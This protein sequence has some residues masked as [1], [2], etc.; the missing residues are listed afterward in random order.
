MWQS[1]KKTSRRLSD[2][3]VQG[4]RRRLPPSPSLSYLLS[5]L[6]GFPAFLLASTMPREIIRKRGKRKTKA[7]DETAAAEEAYQAN[8]NPKPDAPQHHEQERQQQEV[9]GGDGGY[10]RRNGR[11]EDGTEADWVTPRDGGMG[12]IRERVEGDAPW[13]FVDPE[14]RRH[15]VRTFIGGSRVL[16]DCQRR[17]RRGG[18]KQRARRADVGAGSLPS[19]RIR[20]KP[21]SRP[22]M[23]D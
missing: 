18:K 7:T 16:E 15:L 3:A 8:F 12:S 4:F 9:L 11:N 22:S 14:V 19:H 6:L 17:G 23:R 13:G 1:K 2:E 21:T 20:L 5:T 10:G